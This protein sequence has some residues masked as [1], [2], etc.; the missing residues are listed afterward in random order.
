MANGRFYHKATDHQKHHI[1]QQVHKATVQKLM[2]QQ[3]RDGQIVGLQTKTQV[4]D[5][6]NLFADFAAP[7]QPAV[8]FFPI[9]QIGA[10]LEQIVVKAAVP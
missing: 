6:G 10:I 4:T 1:A 3:I 9:K 2:Y 5:G 7:F 8:I